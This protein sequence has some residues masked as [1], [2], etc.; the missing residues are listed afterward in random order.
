MVT[1]PPLSCSVE[2]SIG[3]TSPTTGKIKLFCKGADTMIYDR[4][5]DGQDEIKVCFPLWQANGS[6]RWF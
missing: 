6:G 4:L 1:P 5:A 2:G 3:L